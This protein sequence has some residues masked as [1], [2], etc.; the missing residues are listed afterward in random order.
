V[1]IPAQL[2]EAAP[3]C[4]RRAGIIDAKTEAHAP[5]FHARQVHHRTGRHH[6]GTFQRRRQA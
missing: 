5:R 4:R 1:E 3:Q 2:Q 6:V